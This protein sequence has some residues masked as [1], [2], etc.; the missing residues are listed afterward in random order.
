MKDFLNQMLIT[1]QCRLNVVKNDE[2]GGSE[3]IAVVVMIGIVVLLAIVFKDQIGG[4]VTDIFKTTSER[5]TDVMEP[6]TTQ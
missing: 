6:I 4:L 1:L 3:M 2:T 5:V